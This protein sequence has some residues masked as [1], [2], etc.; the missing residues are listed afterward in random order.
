MCQSLFIVFLVQGPVHRVSLFLFSSRI[1]DWVGYGDPRATTLWIIRVHVVHVYRCKLFREMNPHPLQELN[2]TPLGSR[3]LSGCGHP[4]PSAVGVGFFYV[5]F[6]AHKAIRNHN[7]NYYMQVLPK[8]NHST[9]EETI[10]HVLHTN[11]LLVQYSDCNET[12]NANT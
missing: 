5:S 9:R 10:H 3:K 1:S 2:R 11:I 8:Q 7:E 4:P 6:G 12:V